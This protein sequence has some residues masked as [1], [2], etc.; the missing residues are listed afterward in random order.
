MS[1]PGLPAAQRGASNLGRTIAG[2]LLTLV[3]LML[4]GFLIPRLMGV[5]HYG[6]YAAALAVIAMLQALGSLGLQQVQLRYLPP[7]WRNPESHQEAIRLASAL[8]SLRFFLALLIGGLT[9]LWLTFS[10]Q[11]KLGL[12]LCLLVGTLAVLRSFEEATRSLFLPLGQA[13]TAA[14]FELLRVC[15]NLGVVFLVYKR[16]GFAG[17]FSGLIAV[18]TALFVFG[19]LLLLRRLPVRPCATPFVVLRPYWSYSFSAYLG[20]AA[21]MVHVQLTV[22]AV[23]TW[24]AGR[25]AGILAVAVQS[26]SLSR[27]LFLAARRSLMPILAELEDAGER[28]RLAYWGSL[29]VRYSTAASSV[30]VIGWSLVGREIVWIL[31]GDAFAPVYPVT[32]VILLGVIFFCGGASCIGLLYTRGLAGVAAANTVLYAAVSA[33]GLAMVA[34]DVHPGAGA[35]ISWV[36]VVAAGVYWASAYLSL[37]WFGGLWLPLGRSVLLALPATLAVPITSWDASLELRVITL[38]TFLAL[39]GCF[40]LG[41]G[42]LPASEVREILHTLRRRRPAPGPGDTHP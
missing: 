24:V 11:L 41:L 18:N 28:D 15:L 10:P 40:A 21:S 12:Q 36:Y 17:V 32:T 23:A 2:H 31:L 33:I 37:G 7:F 39:Y 14:G 8:L 20:Q 5:E 3:V 27:N 13:G 1:D 38:V 16:F 42:L 9:V 29:M 26:Y 4:A 22:Y 25:E 30:A 34:L 6:R 19:T 35:A